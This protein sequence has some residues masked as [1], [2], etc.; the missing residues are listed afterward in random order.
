LLAEQE[1]NP[2]NKA[3]RDHRKQ[4]CRNPADPACKAGGHGAPATQLQKVLHDYDPARLRNTPLIVDKDLEEGFRALTIRC[5]R[6]VPP[7]SGATDCVT[8]PETMEQE[9]AQF[10]TTMNPTIAG[11]ERGK[12]RE[13]TLEILFHETGHVQFRE[14]FRANRV[15]ASQPE[16]F[17]QDVLSALNELT[18]MMNEF[19]LRIE[20]LKVS[21]GFS[22]EDREKEMD[23]WR[24][25]RIRGTRQSIT[26]SLRTVRCS[27]NCDEANK[28]IKETIE[29]ATHSWT[30]ELKNQINR[31][32]RDPR[33]SELDLRW[34]FVAPSVPDVP[35]PVPERAKTP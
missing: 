33:W 32:M 19:P 8:V 24:E 6:F 18:A 7:I 29:F 17:T 31:E 2:A 3:K 21:V 5:D 25:R 1:V 23:E 10:N 15:L 14:A 22:P 30:Q 28:M 13:R 35:R 27:C 26:V 34:P 11:E 16:C 12:W 4:V 9:A 20:R